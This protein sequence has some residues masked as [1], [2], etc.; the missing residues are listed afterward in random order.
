MQATIHIRVPH[1]RDGLI[2]ANVGGVPKTCA[3]ANVGA[4]SYQNRVVILS[5]ARSAKKPALSEVEG[6]DLRL[7][8]SHRRT[9]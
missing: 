8:S 4:C 7:S 9:C 2:V 1:V 6:K 5:E 3:V